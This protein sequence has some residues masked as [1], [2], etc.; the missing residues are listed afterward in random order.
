M[1]SEYTQNRR[2]SVM[3]GLSV[4]G[5]LLIFTKDIP[6][7]F[8]YIRCK[9]AAERLGVYTIVNLRLLKAILDFDSEYNSGSARRD[10]SCTVAART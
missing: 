1:G 8:P 9:N 2:I 10:M 3:R 5:F 7:G 4:V 6:N